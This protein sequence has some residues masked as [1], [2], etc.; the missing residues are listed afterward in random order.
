M[1]GIRLMFSILPA[2]LAILGAMFIFFYR[3]DAQTIRTME[4]A[5]AVRHAKANA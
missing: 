1:M 4:A 5:L 3:I 2:A